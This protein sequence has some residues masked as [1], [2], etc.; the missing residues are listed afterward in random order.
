[1]VLADSTWGKKSLTL[2]QGF[3]EGRSQPSP[4]PTATETGTATWKTYRNE[5]YGFEFRYPQNFQVTEGLGQYFLNQK[6]VIELR[7]DSFN[8]LQNTVDAYFNV[9]V[10]SNAKAECEYIPRGVIDTLQN[11]EINGISFTM[12]STK[13]AATGNTYS[14]VIFHY[15]KNTTCYELV[16]TIHESSDGNTPEALPKINEQKI[17]LENQLDQILTTFKFVTQETQATPTSQAMQTY[18]IP[19]DWQTYT[20]NL[21]E[22]AIKL[23]YPDG[24]IVRRNSSEDNRTLVIIRGVPFLDISQPGYYGWSEYKNGSRREWFLENAKSNPTVQNI[25][26]SLVDFQ[27]GNSFYQVKAEK[28]NNLFGIISNDTPIN[29]YFGVINGKAI[30]IRDWRVLSQDDVYRVLQSIEFSGK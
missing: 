18:S 9:S 24:T 29:A 10:K 21:G 4:S 7:S 8:Y 14:N 11:K 27:N 2:K 3:E 26:F 16:S 25:T 13:G 5:Q 6:P 1:M 30:I 20:G 17:K 23:R 22:I 28:I 12:F 15:L 19:S